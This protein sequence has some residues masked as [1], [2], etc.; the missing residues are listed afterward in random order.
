LHSIGRPYASA[1]DG[2]TDSAGSDD[3]S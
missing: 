2:R 1:D 3:D